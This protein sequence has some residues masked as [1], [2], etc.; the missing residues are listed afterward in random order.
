MLTT[1]NRR[2]TLGGAIGGL[3]GGMA[4]ITAIAWFSRARGDVGFANGVIAGG[5]VTMAFIAVAFA[6]GRRGPS[7]LRVA[8]GFADE[9]ERILALGAASHGALAM[10]LVACGFAVFWPDG[11]AIAAAGAVLWSGLL[12]TAASFLIRALR[13]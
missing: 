10:V 2:K 13:N 12:A 9:R 1:K 8:G 7:F 3:I 6:F 4:V 11:P 5:A